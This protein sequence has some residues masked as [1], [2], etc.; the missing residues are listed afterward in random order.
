MWRIPVPIFMCSNKTN[1]STTNM[2]I[3]MVLKV[4]CPTRVR[5]WFAGSKNENYKVHAMTSWDSGVSFLRLTMA[6]Q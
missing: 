6:A 1:K 4:F 3:N 5:W 2:M